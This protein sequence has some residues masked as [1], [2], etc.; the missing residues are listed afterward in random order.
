MYGATALYLAVQ[1]GHRRVVET[2]LEAGAEID[3][4]LLQNAATPLFVAAERASIELASL[5]LSHKASVHVTNWNGLTPLHIAAVSSRRQSAAMI[6]LLVSAGATVDTTDNQGRT[7]LMDVSLGEGARLGADR[8]QV[9]DKLIAKGAIVNH[10]S[11]NGSTALIEAA[12]SEGNAHVAD[13]LLAAG[14]DCTAVDQARVSAQDLAQQRRDFDL[15]KVLGKHQL[16]G[17]TKDQ[18]EQYKREHQK[19]IDISS[20]E[21]D[22]QLA[23][24]LSTLGLKQGATWKQIKEAHRGLNRLLHPDKQPNNR[25]ASQRLLEVNQAIDFMKL[26][27]AKDKEQL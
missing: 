12:R 9:V 10:Q 4:G 15:L 5:L 19:N 21:I 6:D 18:L 1:G 13:K 8:L 27:L 14:A 7:P 26:R 16:C 11:D 17:L 2:L 24:A 3:M 25:Q 20:Q 22:P 23:G